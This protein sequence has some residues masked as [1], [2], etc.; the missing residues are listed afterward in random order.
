[1]YSYVMPRDIDRLTGDL[2]RKPIGTER[3]RVT[4]YLNV[5]KFRKFQ[6]L[7]EGKGL[8]ASKVID[9]WIADTLNEN[10]GKK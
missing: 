6:K 9:A 3:K 1:M 8:A 5:P 4:L 2:R 10:E 7:C